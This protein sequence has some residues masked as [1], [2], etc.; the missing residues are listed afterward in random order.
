MHNYVRNLCG[1][2]G[3]KKATTQ[4]QVVTDLFPRL[5]VLSESVTRLTHA[6]S[7]MLAIK[8]AVGHSPY[9][10]EAGGWHHMPGRGELEGTSFLQGLTDC[11][12]NKQNIYLYMTV[13]NKPSS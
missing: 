10:E 7:L 13:F 4:H 2:F 1:T 12:R 5:R 8:E 11:I 9:L 3:V 6:N